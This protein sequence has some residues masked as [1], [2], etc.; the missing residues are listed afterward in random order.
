M[1]FFLVHTLKIYRAEEVYF[2]AFLASALV[3]GKW[4]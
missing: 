2:H 3:G 4:L 1:L